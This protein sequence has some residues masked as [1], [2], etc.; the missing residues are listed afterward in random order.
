M[1]KIVYFIPLIF[2]LT[3]LSACE[4]GVKSSSNYVSSTNSE[5]GTSQKTDTSSEPAVGPQGDPTATFNLQNEEAV[6]KTIKQLKNENGSTSNSTTLYRIQG[7]VQFPSTNKNGTTYGNFDLLD[8]TDYIDVYGCSSKATSIVHSG[9]TYSYSNSTTFSSMK[10]SAGDYIEMEGIYVWYEGSGGIS[11][12]QGYV[13]KLWRRGVSTITAES[14]TESEPTDVSGSYYSSI[15][16][17]DSGVTLETKLHNLMDSTHSNYI[18]Y[19]SLFTH[20]QT[21]DTTSG[22]KYKCFYSGKGT[23]SVN[24]E[25]VWAQSLSGGG[26]SSTKLYGETYGGSDLHHLRAAISSYNS[27]RSNA[28]FGP[29]YGNQSGMKNIPYEDGTKNWQTGNVFEPTDSLKGDVARIVMYMYIHYSSSFGGE[30]RE[31]YGTMNLAM[32]MAPNDVADCK[33]LLRKWNA[34]DPVSQEEINR[35]NYAANLQGNRNPFIDHPTYADRMWA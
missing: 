5:T 21:T 7:F 24:R 28:A 16:S 34:L 19:S 8:D 32:I 26:T 1:K 9:T 4:I 25:H 3:T 14:Y 15:S 27:Q 23:N 18:S 29:V 6:V 2:A 30:A 33:K 22:Y 20:F 17:S 13:T 11:E 12:F 35:N 10:I 31:F